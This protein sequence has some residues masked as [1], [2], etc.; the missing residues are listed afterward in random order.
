MDYSLIIPKS[1]VLIATTSVAI[2]SALG[3]YLYQRKRKWKPP[4]QWE[5]VG[6]VTDL[7]IYPLKSGRRIVVKKAEC[8]QVGF[9]QTADDEK[10]YQLRDR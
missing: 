10:V 9:K 4:Q 2:L 3:I 6:K 1:Y 8:T 5:A 7:Y